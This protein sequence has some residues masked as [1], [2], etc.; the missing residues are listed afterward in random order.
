MN[1]EQIKELQGENGLGEIQNW[2]DT[3]TAW[4]LEGSV[5]RQAMSLL[6]AGACMLP[7]E[8]HKDYWGNTVPSRNSLKAGTKGTLQN[9]IEYWT[10]FTNNELQG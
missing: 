10:R 9:C 3:G 2:I 4:L 5:G 1:I 6:E 8:D 7:E